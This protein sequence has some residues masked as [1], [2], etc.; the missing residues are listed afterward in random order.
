MVP[1]VAGLFSVMVM[2]GGGL[3]LNP[4]AIVSWCVGGS[5]ISI[6]DRRKDEA[7]NAT[8]SLRLR[9][10]R[11]KKAAMAKR[12]AIPS[13]PAPIPPTI[14]PVLV[15]PDGAAEVEAAFSAP[16]VP[17][18]DIVIV[19][20]DVL[21][22]GNEGNEVLVLEVLVLEVVLVEDEVVLLP[23]VWNGLNLSEV[24]ENGF[25]SVV[26]IGR[27]VGIVCVVVLDVVVDELSPP[28]NKKLKISPL[29]SL[30][31]FFVGLSNRPRACRRCADCAPR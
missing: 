14:L 31:E 20:V 17:L 5:G 4:A 12:A 13:T 30:F 3:G 15:A 21:D 8:S 23:V 24:V 16:C 26:M 7:S 6:A 28:P 19:I 22:E 25:A 18:D 27:I 11:R 9:M 1:N 29:E 2:T 10:R